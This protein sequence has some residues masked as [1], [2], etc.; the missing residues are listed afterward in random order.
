MAISKNGWTLI[1]AVVVIIC[2]LETEKVT[3]IFSLLSPEPNEDDDV[4]LHTRQKRE[5]SSDLNSVTEYEVDVELNVTDFET[6]DRLRTLL[7]SGNFSLTLG[8][9]LNL[10]HIEITTVCSQNGSEFQCRC[11]DQFVWSYNSCLTYGACDEMIN[12]AC[13]CINKIPSDGLYCQPK[14]DP[15][16]TI[17]E[18]EVII[19]LGTTDF[20]QLRNSLQAITLPVQINSQVKISEIDITTVCTPN[21]NSY[22]CTCEEQYRWPCDLCVSYGSCDSISNDTCGC[23]HGLPPDGQQCQPLDSNF[24][25]CPS[26]T[27]VPTTDTTQMNTTSPTTVSSTVITTPAFLHRYIVSVVLNTTDS[28]LIN[29]LRNVLRNN[30]YP[31]SVHNNIR[32]NSVDISTVCT[33]NNNS[34]QCTCEEQY[35]W[36]CDLC[37]SYGSC[38]SISNDTCGC[39]HGLPPDGQQCQ[40]LDSNFTVCP[41][42]TSVPTTDTTQM[43]TTSPTTVSSTVITTPAFLHRYIVSVVLNTTDSALINQLRNVLRNNSYPISVHNNIRINS[44]DIST[45]CTPNN[46]SYQCTC[47]EQYRWP[48]DLCVSYGSC[49]SISNDTCGC[50]HGLPPD[51][52][53]CQ[54]LDSNFTVCPS[55]TSVPTTDTTQMNTTSPTT[56]SSTVITTPAFLHRYIVSVVLNTTDSALINQLRNVLRNNSYPISVHNNIRINSVDISTVCTPNN[57]SYQCTCEEQY[58]WPCD[59]C[60]SYGSCDSISN[61]TCGCIHGL[62]PDGQQCQPLDSNFTVCPS[63]TSVPTTDT[64]QMNTTSPTTVSSTVITTPAFLHRYIVSVVL[65]TTDSALINQLRNVLR[66]NSYP[67][68]VH[69]NIRINSVDIST[70]CTPNNNSYQCTCEEQYRWPCDLCVSY[71][72][73]DSIS[74]DTCGCIHGLPPD[75]QQCQPLDSNF[76]V[77]PSTT[78]VPFTPLQTTVTST[79]TIAT[80][81]PNTTTPFPNTTTPFPNTTTPFPNTTTPFPNTTTP[82][83]NTTTPFPNTT[84]PFPNT[85]TPFPNTTTPFP[86]TTTPFPNTT[87]P[88]PNTTTPFPN[89]TTPFPN[90]TTP[91]PNTTAPFPNT[92]TPFPN[93]TTPFLNTTTPFSNTTTLLPNTI[94]PFLNTTTLLPNNTT[95]FPNTTTPFPNTTTPFPNTTTPFPNTTTPFLN[96]TTLFPNTTTLL[97]NTTTPFSNTTTPFP[98]TT[99]PFPDSTTPFPNTTTP[100]PNTTTPFPNTTTPFPN[101]TTLLPNTTT[102]FL[103]TTTPFPNTTTP[104]PNTTTPF[105]NTTSTVPTTTSTAPSTTTTF[106]NTTFTAPTTTSTAP[107]TT[108]MFSNTTTTDPNTTTIFPNTT[109]PT[110]TPTPPINTTATHIP[111]TTTNT[112]TPNIINT[113]TPTTTTPMPTTTTTITTTTIP[114]T[115]TTT[116]PTTTIKT[117]TTTTP[118]TIPTTMTSTNTTITTEVTHDPPFETTTTPTTTTPTTIPPTTI[119]PTT[120]PPTTIPPT[121]IPPTTIPPTTIPPTTV[122]PTTI[123]PTT[124]PPTTIPPTTIPPTVPPTTIPPTTTPPKGKKLEM[125]IKLDKQYQPELADTS[126][127]AFKNLRNQVHPVLDNEYKS[128]RG[129]RGVS[130]NAFK[131]GSIVTEYTVETSQINSDEVTAANAKIPDAMKGVAPVIGSVTVSFTASESL[132]FPQSTYTGKSMTLKCGPPPSDIDLGV[133]DG[134]EWKFKGVTLRDGRRYSIS[135]NNLESSLTVNEVILADKGS[136]ECTLKGTN[137]N[138]IQKGSVNN[139]KQAPNIRVS[140]AINAKCDGSFLNLTCCVQSNYK[141]T[142]YSSGTSLN[143]VGSLETG[144]YCIKIPIEKKC[145]STK[146][147]IY[148]CQENTLKEYKKTTTVTLFPEPP[149]CV[150]NIYGTGRVGDISVIGCDTG[151]E[152]SRTAVCETSGRWRLM[153]DT[154]IVEEIKE[155][156]TESEDLNPV[157][158]PDFVDKLKETVETEKEAITGSSATISAI[159]EIVDTVSNVTKTVE[160]SVMKNVLEVADELTSDSAAPA[161]KTLNTNK[162]S[163]A[164]SQF[165]GSLEHL[166]EGLQGEFSIITQRIMLNRTTFNNSYSALLNFSVQ[167]DIPDSQLDNVSITT[168]VFSSLNNIMP[169]RDASFNV[170]L[171]TTTNSTENDTEPV[172]L[173][174]VINADVVLIKVN[175]EINNVTLSFD[176]SNDSLPLNPQCVFWNFSLLDGLGAWDDEGCTFLSDINNTVTCRCN[177]LT[178]FSILMSTDIPESIREP[179]K[180][181]TYIGVGIS[182]GSLVICLI[183]EGYVW[184]AVTR[185]STAFMRHVSIVNTALSL[186]IADI[187]FII[188]AF[189]AKKPPEKENEDYEI[190]LGPCSTAT[191]FMHFFYLALFF[192]MLVFG[193]LLFYRMVMVFSH[194]SKSTMLAVGFCVGYGGPLII[195]VVTVA[196]TAPGNGYIRRYN[197]CWLNWHE[198]KAL[199]ALVIPALTIVFINIIILFVVLYK[200]LRSG[201]IGEANESDSHTIKVIV[202]CVLILTPLFGLTWSLGVGTMVAPKN[203]GIHIAF[204]FFNSLQG[205]FILIFGTLFDSKIRATLLRKSPAM[206]S[207][208]SGSNRR[209]T[210]SGAFS[211]LLSRLPG[212]RDVYHLSHA[213]SSTTDPVEVYSNI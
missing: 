114:T 85:T 200:M 131:P 62:P 158:V 127:Q 9:S 202:R 173:D 110:Y 195:A 75:G 58:R 22:Q 84:T 45:V 71:G 150:D 78:S 145:D 116:T 152:G 185:T 118:T 190:P 119:P 66:N 169:A 89:T 19:E 95:T 210:S 74:N 167:V 107:S 126:S 34:Y 109:T 194:M 23:I 56:V 181:I 29:Q 87:T 10:T 129:F 4:L 208:G 132:T 18:Y 203:E 188:A 12:D 57:N 86:N 48:C 199:L 59:L 93:T 32:I 156:L 38:D 13:T 27:S 50:I 204:A 189:V 67:I 120:I 143:D 191:F 98:N 180:I 182:L 20:D 65:N 207:S 25:V 192:W 73:C 6:V 47:E 8:P 135:R 197:T 3:Q 123:P 43:N 128:L 14:Q 139:I 142:W 161:W 42:T 212:R 33:P 115:I 196:A 17:F 172:V 31:I 63:T 175:Q 16:Q 60:V 80:T 179:L 100:F 206:V 28:A 105:P 183:I 171:L 88:F 40:P 99:T 7:Q 41:S 111:T 141:V 53:Q 92:T 81:A 163:N 151:Q 2:I 35:R 94:A 82:F 108:T 83:P 44:V 187:C 164:S 186:L 112:T 170:S 201:G 146:N 165:L 52:Q 91:F 122:P 101:T 184:K 49:D 70:V 155:L 51:G 79:T 39:I 76:T 117:T 106:P 157:L 77:C 138:Y 37:V 36:P 90:T 69:N 11:E 125:S 104:F 140:G 148:I 55:T 168:I 178:S 193:L 21:N 149:A 209:S 124:I 154:C 61:D 137:L 130:I 159:V 134:V 5:A 68:S 160:K 121:T 174:N 97:P 176:K 30:S 54:P 166:S 211:A 162:S 177:H 136:Y 15:P 133:L 102:P 153:D 144:E 103:N 64:T 96:T 1:A 147:T 72:S 213:T 198:T 113:T 205:L 26:T 24:T 46:N